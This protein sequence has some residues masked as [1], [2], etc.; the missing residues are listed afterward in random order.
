MAKRTLARQNGCGR[1]GATRR[2]EG[3]K[4]EPREA[5]KRRTGEKEKEEDKGKTTGEEELIR[6]DARQLLRAARRGSWNYLEDRAR[7]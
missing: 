5:E 1:R 4:G 6:S 3:G 2:E 7:W